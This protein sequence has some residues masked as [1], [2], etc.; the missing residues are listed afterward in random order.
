M[1]GTLYGHCPDALR[2]RRLSDTNT[3]MMVTSMYNTSSWPAHERE[4]Q[5]KNHAHDLLMSVPL[6]ACLEGKVRKALLCVPAGH[7][8]NLH[9]AQCAVGSLQ[10]WTACI[11]V[12]GEVS[13]PCQR[14]GCAGWQA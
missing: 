10:R 5:T 2:H 1:Q 8:P 3:D 14:F 4:F 11:S 12:L 6:P 9:A 13:V 7:L